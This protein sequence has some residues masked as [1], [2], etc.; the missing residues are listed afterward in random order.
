MIRAERLGAVVLL[1]C[2]LVASAGAAQGRFTYV[3]RGA[4]RTI[5]VRQDGELVVRA[6]N[7]TRDV[8]TGASFRARLGTDRVLLVLLRDVNLSQLDLN[9]PFGFLNQY[10]QVKLS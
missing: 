10:K 8:R 3:D 6:P 4:E 2:S 5:E 7:A 1:A 9:K